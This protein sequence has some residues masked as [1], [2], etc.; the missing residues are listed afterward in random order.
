MPFREPQDADLSGFLPEFTTN[1]DLA[2]DLGFF[3]FIAPA[4]RIENTVG[5]FIEGQALTATPTFSP[6]FVEDFDPFQNLDGYEEFI[7]SFAGANSPADIERVKQKIDRERED[8]EFL[9]NGGL[10][11]FLAMFVAGLIDPI[12][13]IPFGAGFTKVRTTGRILEGAVA[14][15][16]AGILSMTATEAILQ[17]TQTQRRFGESALNITAATALS[18]VLGSAAGALTRRQ[19]DDLAELLDESLTLEDIPA[20]AATSDAD[21]AATTRGEPPIDVAPPEEAA[22]LFSVERTVEDLSAEP[23]AGGFDEHDEYIR[24]NADEELSMRDVMSGDEPTPQELAAAE[25][26]VPEEPAIPEPEVRVAEQ[27]AVIDVGEAEPV[28]VEGRELTPGEAEIL[29]QSTERAGVPIDPTESKLGRLIRIIDPTSGKFRQG[30]GDPE[31]AIASKRIIEAFKRLEDEPENFDEILKDFGVPDTSDLGDVKKAVFALERT[32]GKIFPDVQGAMAESQVMRDAT[33]NAVGMTLLADGHSLG[34][35]SPKSVQRLANL[36]KARMYQAV[37]ELRRQFNIIRGRD[38]SKGILTTRAFDALVNRQGDKGVTWLQFKKA[39]YYA[40]ARNDQDLPL[41]R[42]EVEAA[43]KSVR[44]EVLEHFRLAAEADDVKLLPKDS[45]PKGTISYVNRVWLA[46]A[47]NANREELRLII[48]RHIQDKMEFLVKAGVFE[49]DLTPAQLT[50]QANDSIERILHTP[51]GR[52]AYDVR[53]GKR[54]PLAARTLNISDE[55]INGGNGGTVFVETDIERL[56]HF[57]TNTMATDIEITRMFGD[58]TA[59]LYGDPEKGFITR[60]YQRLMADAAGDPKRVLALGKERD[61]MLRNFNFMIDQMRGLYAIPADPTAIGPRIL[62]VGRQGMLMSNLGN[63]ALVSTIDVSRFPQV[64]GWRRLF[65][66]GIIPFIRNTKGMLEQMSQEIKLR[67]AVGLEMVRD[68]HLRA[69]A[70]IGETNAPGTKFERFMDAFVSGFGLVSLS[71]PWNAGAKQF[72]G[73]L[74]QAGFLDNAVKWADD[75][76]GL[77]VDQIESMGDF[78]MDRGMAQRIAAQYQEFGVPAN[79]NKGVRIANTLAWTDQEAALTLRLAINK[80]VEELIV[81]PGAASMPPWTRAILG[82]RDL[83]LNV[84]QFKSFGGTAT[85]AVLIKGLQGDKARFLNGMAF[86]TFMGMMVYMTKRSLAG[87]EITDDPLVLIANGLDQSG[88]LGYLSDLNNVAEHSIGVG[89]SS[90]TGERT[91][92]R[93]FT[94]NTTTALLG[95]TAGAVDSAGRIISETLRGEFDRDTLR[96]LRRLWPYQGLF[97]LRNLLVDPAEEAVAGALGL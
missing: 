45:A 77:A 19:F 27:E 8:R 53:I 17:A 86:A 94:P 25:A 1:I 39:V 74:L 26:R 65:G 90:F 68:S 75:A 12:N 66:D 52:T 34:V 41:R 46:D 93:Y 4:F 67:S 49:D 97:Y 57:F 84:F 31:D 80:A 24:L 23:R 43:A 21:F 3:D 73:I 89:V 76:A 70:D 83:A 35:A 78:F 32:V 15:A 82:S 81:T 85:Q 95:P 20:R 96:K 16:R 37:L 6:D 48:E 14:G 63:V 62:R 59:R 55:L 38:P 69:V 42:P 87:Q 18:A 30:P 92:G 50:Q 13:L 72:A 2:D 11:A 40:A 29:R 47:I 56:I 28:R 79:R 58:P 51:S 64:V 33:W 60:D 22:D 44:E 54:G 5:S 61:K 88:N 7:I 71:S 91:A 36:E 9:A 10:P